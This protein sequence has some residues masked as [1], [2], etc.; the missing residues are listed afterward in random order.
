MPVMETPEL[1]MNVEAIVQTSVYNSSNTDMLQTEDKF[2]SVTSS[3]F[4][5]VK[6]QKDTVA[7]IKQQDSSAPS[8]EIDDQ[9]VKLPDSSR[10]THLSIIPP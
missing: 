5:P 8:S 2:N 4:M 3:T 6:F 1:K 9:V 7:L 10:T